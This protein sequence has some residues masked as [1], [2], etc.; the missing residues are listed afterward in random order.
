MPEAL[1]RAQPVYDEMRTELMAGQYLD[2]LEQVSGAGS[3]E[4]AMRVLRFKSAKYTVERPLHMG[5][6]LASAGPELL[7]LYSEYG[8]AVGEAFQ[9]RDDVLGVFGDP[10]QTGKPAQ[11]HAQLCHEDGPVALTKR[12][13]MPDIRSQFSASAASC[14]LPALVIV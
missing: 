12:D 5:A 13:M 1:L 10:E 7:V 9:L 14:F 4:R 6:L 2:L 11:E 8:L 3:V